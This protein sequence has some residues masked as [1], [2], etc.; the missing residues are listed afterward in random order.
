[1]DVRPPVPA[2]PQ[3]VRSR[4]KV[5]TVV[6]VHFVLRAV[7][8]MASTDRVDVAVRGASDGAQTAYGVK[9]DSVLCGVLENHLLIVGENC[10]AVRSREVTALHVHGDIVHR[11]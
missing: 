5:N 3:G 9:A 8:R 2:L 1:M 6:N 7:V 10:E 4:N 11:L